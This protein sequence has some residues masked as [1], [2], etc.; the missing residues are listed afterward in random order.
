MPRPTFEGV[1]ERSIELNTPVEA[2]FAPTQNT[3]VYVF[4]IE[5]PQRIA[6][7]LAARDSGPD[8]TLVARLFDEQG[9]L[10][11]HAEA[12]IGQPLGMDEWEV[13]PGQ[14]SLQL[15]GPETANRMLTITLVSRPAPPMG[16]GTISYGEAIL[17]EIET[18]GQRDRWLFDGRAGEQVRMTMI[19]MGTDPYLELYNSAGKLLAS[20]DDQI[21]R[22]AAIELTLPT[23]GTYTIVARM[24]ND[25]QTGTYR[26]ALEKIR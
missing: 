19:T 1:E 10:V 5:Q 15:F 7:E 2:V 12:I 9:E 6:V 26:I 23:D 8:L 11:S 13:T 4:E 21:E 24:V 14:Y 25:D 16:G 3:T 20:N 17:G 22:N 18:Q